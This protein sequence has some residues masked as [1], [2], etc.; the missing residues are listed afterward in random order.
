MTTHDA[1][2]A[3]LASAPFLVWADD[4]ARDFGFNDGANLMQYEA[5][6]Y[7]LLLRIPYTYHE[8]DYEAMQT[9]L[10]T[11]VPEPTHRIVRPNE[12]DYRIYP[13]ASLYITSNAE[14]ACWW[15]VEEYVQDFL[16]SYDEDQ[17]DAE[18]RELVAYVQ[19]KD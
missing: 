1:F 19:K 15:D 3:L 8:G 14:D 18:T 17:W 6:L 13:D 5:G 16:T 10:N 7:G 11:L 9:A 2:T 12:I 4:I